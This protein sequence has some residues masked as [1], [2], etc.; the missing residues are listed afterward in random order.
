[1]IIANTPKKKQLKVSSRRY[2][3]CMFGDF[4]RALQNDYRQR[5]FNISWSKDCLNDALSPEDMAALTRYIKK[6]LKHRLKHF[7]HYR[8]RFNLDTLTAEDVGN[9]LNI[10]GVITI[11]EN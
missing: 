8:R 1:M 9:K 11:R 2:G 10:S 4:E 3:S 7:K 6:D 5:A